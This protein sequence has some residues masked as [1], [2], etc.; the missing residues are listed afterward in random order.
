MS[1]MSQKKNHRIGMVVPS[2]N[3]IAEDDFRRF[4]PPD[5]PYHVHRIRLRSQPGKVTVEDLNRAY[6]EAVDQSR[7]VRDMNP[8]TIVFNCTG[9]SV[10][11]A[12]LGDAVLAERMTREL[13]VPCTNTMV[14]IKEAL[15]ALG[16]VRIVHV[17]PFADDSAR[18]ERESLQASGFT[19]VKSVGLNF[20]DA[21]E[22]ALMEPAR[23]VEIA[24]SHMQEGIDGMLLSCANVR[25][26]EAA[27]PLERELGLPVI[28]SN[29]AVLWQLLRMSDWQ[30]N[31]AGA[32]RLFQLH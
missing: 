6:L 24:R 5:V 12:P 14:A 4:C 31:I 15:R 32:G 25:A 16:L 28:T 1:G 11:N 3:T 2:L 8:A 13:G 27:E 20:T 10:A 23:L 29:G 26:M 7:F 22:A 19:V 9:A 30:G 17:C 21:R 18:I